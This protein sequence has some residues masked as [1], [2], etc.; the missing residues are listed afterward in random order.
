ML[1]ELELTSTAAEEV[2]RIA[3]DI[4]STEAEEVGATISLEE[5]VGAEMTFPFKSMTDPSFNVI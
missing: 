3:E 5:E 1:M 2:G 4:G